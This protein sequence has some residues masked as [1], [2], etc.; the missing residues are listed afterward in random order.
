MLVDR[1][2]FR[3]FATNS[4]SSHS[5]IYVDAESMSELD[6]SGS[7]H[8]FGWANFTLASPTAKL[9]Y[10]TVIVAN[11]I[12]VWK[13]WKYMDKP[14]DYAI[15]NSIGRDLMG[16]Y[17]SELYEGESFYVDHQSLFQ[18]PWTGKE[19]LNRD[20]VRDF[21]RWACRKDTAILGGND[22]DERHPFW[23]YCHDIEDTHFALEGATKAIKTGDWYTL[24]NAKTGAK[25]RFSFLREKEVSPFFRSSVPELVDLKITD[26]CNF[27]CKFCYQD[28]TPEGHHAPVESIYAFLDQCAELGVFEIA[29]GG[30]EPSLH[31]DFMSILEYGHNLGIVMN[32]TTKNPQILRDE[33]VLK[34]TGRIGFSVSSIEEFKK[35]QDLLD[36]LDDKVVIHY[37]MGSMAEEGLAHLKALAENDILLLGYKKLGRGA[38]FIP[39]DNSN[40]LRLFRGCLVFIDTKLAAQY[41]GQLKNAGVYAKTYSTEEGVDN[42]YVDLVARKYGPSSFC[43]ERHIHPMSG[44]LLTDWTKMEAVKA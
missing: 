41:E 44:K 16:Q 29:I 30:G 2:R 17:W 9:R 25:V 43:D 3:G 18:I 14:I 23:E 40:W 35:N 20:Y 42:I 1:I 28:S 12:C 8:E 27:G 5:L 11:S 15:L 24:F 34:S 36:S 26:Y 22:N 6:D 10:V 7:G 37:V 4:S 21:T 19:G 33:G 39:H 38:G 13:G 32:F 31:P